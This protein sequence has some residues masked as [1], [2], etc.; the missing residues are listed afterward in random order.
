M[1]KYYPQSTLL[2]P[3]GR[4]GGEKTKGCLTQEANGL[5]YN[6]DIIE[7]ANHNKDSKRKNVRRA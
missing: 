6:A 4:V 1:L 7:K 5:L 3:Q 2:N